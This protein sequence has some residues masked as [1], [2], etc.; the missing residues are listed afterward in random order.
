MKKTL[1]VLALVVLA[2]VPVAAKGSFGVGLELGS[3]VGATF[4]YDFKGTK[5][6]WEGYTTVGFGFIGGN[7]IDAV[8]GAQVKV[9]DFQ[10]SKAKFDVKVGAQAGLLVTLGESTTFG[11]SAR[12]T[13][14][15]SYDWLWKNVGNFTAYLR[16]APGVKLTFSGGGVSPAFNFAGALGLVYHF[17]NPSLV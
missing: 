1:I 13:V 9:V 14:A 17:G 4:N 15:L 10:I 7:N 6:D 3:P 5:V 2:I 11:M 16:L 8:F 12:G